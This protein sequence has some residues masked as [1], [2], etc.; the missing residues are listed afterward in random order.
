MN[1]ALSGVKYKETI[2]RAR[3]HSYHVISGKSNPQEI[4]KLAVHLHSTSNSLRFQNWQYISILSSQPGSAIFRNGI[5][6][7]EEL[8]ARFSV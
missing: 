4:S 6:H 7:R 5:S 1:D 8:F 2:K 3:A